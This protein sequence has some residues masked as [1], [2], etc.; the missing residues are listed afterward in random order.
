[1]N[2]LIDEI[3]N[4]GYHPCVKTDFNENMKSLE[5]FGYQAQKSGPI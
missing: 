4:K 2:T 1:M 3:L 5:A